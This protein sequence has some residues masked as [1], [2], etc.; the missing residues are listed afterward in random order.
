[1]LA[2]P[3]NLWFIDTDLDAVNGLYALL[4]D[5]RMSATRSSYSP[6]ESQRHVIDLT[7]REL[8]CALDDRRR[9]PAARPSATG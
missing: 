5:Q 3:A 6:R 7:A 8:C 9:A 2:H 4:G 1:M